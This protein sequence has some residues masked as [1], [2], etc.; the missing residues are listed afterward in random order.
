MDNSEN[1]KL[2]Y[3]ISL[4]TFFLLFLHFTIG[5]LLLGKILE[6]IPP[7]SDKLYN[8]LL[9]SPVY[10]VLVLGLASCI[11]GY[12]AAKEQK[13]VYFWVVP[14]AL[15]VCFITLLLIVGS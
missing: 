3:Y 1:K 13:V 9:D 12:F 6:A 7:D 5:P 15:Y 11:S 14:T 2:P 8:L 10:V 4:S